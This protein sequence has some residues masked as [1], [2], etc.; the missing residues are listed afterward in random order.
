MATINPDIA[1]VLVKKCFTKNKLLRRYP[2]S[3][4]LNILKPLT[5]QELILYVSFL[6]SKTSVL[7]CCGG[8]MRRS[9]LREGFLPWLW[10]AE[11]LEA[12][13]AFLSLKL[14]IPEP[15]LCND[16][17]MMWFKKLQYQ[18]ESR[19][20]REGIARGFLRFRGQNRVL[21]CTRLLPRIS[22]FT[23]TEIIL[24]AAV[25]FRPGCNL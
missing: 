10:R 9:A 7:I 2:P 21:G 4:F 1:L 5:S 6:M 23:L 11:A 3:Y 16:L 17:G 13:L 20:R 25:G 19:E 22:A 24:R 18:N 15:H 12:K 14:T 8:Y